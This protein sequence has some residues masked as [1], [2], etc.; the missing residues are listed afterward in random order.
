MS[1]HDYKQKF[2]QL[3]RF[4]PGLCVTEKAGVNKFV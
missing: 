3:E 4:A 2:I 1:V